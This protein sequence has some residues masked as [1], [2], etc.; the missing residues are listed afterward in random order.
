MELA[1]GDGVSEDACIVPEVAAVGTVSGGAE[2]VPATGSTT[3]HLGIL[4]LLAALAFGTGSV[5]LA[6]KPTSGRNTL[7]AMLITRSAWR[8]LSDSARLKQA[9]LVSSLVLCSFL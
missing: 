2:K 9:C 4:R 5:G 3:A 6:G 1:V 7:G 8:Q